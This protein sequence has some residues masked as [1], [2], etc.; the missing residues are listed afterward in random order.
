MI[1]LSSWIDTLVFEH[2]IMIVEN[3]IY[4]KLKQVGTLVKDSRF[5][6][7]LQILP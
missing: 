1:E 6:M 7:R 5:F 3:T 4:K 2:T